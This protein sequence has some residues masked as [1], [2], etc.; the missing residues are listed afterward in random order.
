MN[1]IKILY[2]IPTKASAV[3]DETAE[4]ALLGDRIMSPWRLDIGMIISSQKMLPFIVKVAPHAA[5]TPP[6]VLPVLQ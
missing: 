1:A 3:M 6:P 5:P 2:A 4:E